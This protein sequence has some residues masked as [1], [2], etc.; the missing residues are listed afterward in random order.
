[1]GQVHCGICKIGLLV[2]CTYRRQNGYRM[3]KINTVRQST[4]MIYIYIYIYIHNG[5]TLFLPY[6]FPWGWC[7]WIKQP[8]SCEWVSYFVW[9][10]FEIPRKIS[11]PYLKD[12]IFYTTLKFLELSKSSCPLPQVRSFDVARLEVEIF[13]SLWNLHYCRGA[14][15]MWQR[16]ENFNPNPATTR[17]H[18]T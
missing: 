4:H 5:T 17:L 10:P 7:G 9:I 8:F 13:V 12:R 3:L 2:P 11:Y 15:G 6:D 14:C 18:H 16:L 1:M